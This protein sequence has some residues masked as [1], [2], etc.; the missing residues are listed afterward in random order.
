MSRIIQ[1]TRAVMETADSGLEKLMDDAIQTA[2]DFD[3]DE[4]DDA[5]A[6]VYGKDDPVLN[7]IIQDGME[8]PEETFD[9]VPPVQSDAVPEGYEEDTMIDE[10][11]NDD[12]DDATESM[13]ALESILGISIDSY[14][15][16]S[17]KA[18]KDT[19][20]LES[21][22]GIAIEGDE[23][24]EENNDGWDKVNDLDPDN[25]EDLI[26][27][28]ETTFQPSPTKISTRKEQHPKE[29]TSAS[30]ESLMSLIGVTE[31]DKSDCDPDDDECDDEN[32]DSDDKST[33]SDDTKDES[34]S[35]SEDTK[36]GCAKES[37]LDDLMNIF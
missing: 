11:Y 27:E 16:T 10:R 31:S 3:E 6:C 15:K 37:W 2:Y 8:N 7:E 18:K 12:F 1:S 35:E 23:C 20:V 22:L 14:K 33:D 36:E 29:E 9:Q 28:D 25:T 32:A 21:I 19:S 13:S 26:D 5:I 34:E 30:V 24:F 17:S 4:A